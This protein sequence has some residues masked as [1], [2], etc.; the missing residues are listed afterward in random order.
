MSRP[1]REL[2]EA[3]AM[4]RAEREMFYKFMAQINGA[5]IK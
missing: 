1:L 2:L 5:K 3:L 4:V